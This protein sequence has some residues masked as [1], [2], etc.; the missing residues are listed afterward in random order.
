MYRRLKKSGIFKD[1]LTKHGTGRVERR[2]R[3]ALYIGI[4]IGLAAGVFVILYIASVATIIQDLLPTLIQATLIPLI[5]ITFYIIGVL[6][7]DDDI[8]RE[9]KADIKACIEAS[10]KLRKGGNSNVNKRE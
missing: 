5:I 1:N 10:E 4:G 6:D 8:Y 7:A 3:T 9:V 2:A